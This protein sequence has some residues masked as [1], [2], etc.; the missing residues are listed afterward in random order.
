MLALSGETGWSVRALL[1]GA[2]SHIVI[3]LRLALV[4]AW[5]SSIPIAANITLEITGR[6]RSVLP[7]RNWNPKARVQSPVCIVIGGVARA[8]LDG[9][10]CTLWG[11]DRASADGYARTAHSGA[12]QVI[13]AARY[14]ISG[15]RSAQLST[16]GGENAALCFLWCEPWGA[17]LCALCLTALEAS[18]VNSR[19]LPYIVP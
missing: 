15:F 2:V 12:A 16:A 13:A 1:R 5:P 11:G 6:C 10:A 7:A 3:G 18:V 9:A 19:C 4:S 8:V 14:N 17:F